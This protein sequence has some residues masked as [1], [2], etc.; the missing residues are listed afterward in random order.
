MVKQIHFPEVFKGKYYNE[1]DLIP[2]GKLMA[3]LVRKYAPD[4]DLRELA[5][6]IV[7]R[8]GV[9]SH[10]VLGEA[11]EL[12]RYVQNRI[13]YRGEPEGEYIQSPNLTL[14]LESGD[15]DCMSVLYN[16]LAHALGHKVGF[17]FVDA[18]RDGEFSHVLCVDDVKGQEY[19]IELTKK[20]PQGFIPPHTKQYIYWV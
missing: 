17:V 2:V 1:S 7:N 4:P 6:N 14:R 11:R 20:V 15:C 9:A 12:Q 8:A 19:F 13:F 5:L 16:S 18:R 3:D 10:D